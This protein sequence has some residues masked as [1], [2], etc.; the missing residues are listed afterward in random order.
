MAEFITSDLIKGW[1]DPTVG[2]KVKSE[3]LHSLIRKFVDGSFPVLSSEV[4][5]TFITHIC[6][7]GAENGELI[8]LNLQLLRI[9]L[10]D[11]SSQDLDC[12]LVLLNFLLVQSTILNTDKSEFYQAKQINVVLEAD[13][14]MVNLLF[15][16]AKARV[17]FQNEPFDK[18]LPRIS[19]LIN[20]LT[21]SGSSVPEQFKNW[22]TEEL[23]ELLLYDLKITFIMTAHVRRLQT[24]CVNDLEKTHIFQQIVSRS[25]EL[26]DLELFDK[27][28]KAATILPLIVQWKW[29]N[30]ALKILFN[31]YH[32]AKLF[33]LEMAKLCAFDC[34]KILRSTALDSETKQNAVNLLAVLP[35]TLAYLCPQVNLNNK[36]DPG[37][38]QE[39]YDMRFVDALLRTFEQQID[40]YELEGNEQVTLAEHLAMFLTALN[41][42]CAEHKAARRYC[43]LQVIPP[44]KA[45]DVEHRPDVGVAFRN[46]I[47]RLMTHSNRAGELAAEFLFVL[48][49]RSVGRLIK[50]C[51]FGHSAGLLANYGFLGQALGPKHPSD[52]EDSETE[53]YKKV[54]EKINPVTGHI[55]PPGQFEEF[56]R[57]LDSMSEEQKEYEVMK[58]VNSLDK[59]MDQGIIAPGTI[60]EDGHLRPVKHVAEII[61]D[62]KEEEP[63]EESD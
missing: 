41:Q 33:D 50:Y 13:K 17:N 23:E 15:N 34:S 52:S 3:Q 6:S 49:K 62:V 29:L 45:Q 11:K 47:V 30:E 26:I 35:T 22:K 61:K 8:E 40:Q 24:D 16:S 2:F 25:M 44:L 4:K 51:G 60:G 53:E 9:I 27:G 28:T 38:V 55:P 58:L 5:E 18:L 63:G 31:L 59:L 19:L 21:G 54:E 43:R 7:L 42:L 48:C 14:C 39:G 1:A 57:S 37:P 10:R 46:K 36:K 20:V 12:F 56:Q 32:K